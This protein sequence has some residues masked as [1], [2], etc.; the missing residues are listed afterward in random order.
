MLLDCQ[1]K[2]EILQ[3]FSVGPQYAFAHGLQWDAWVHA[4][5]LGAT[6]AISSTALSQSDRLRYR[7]RLS[8]EWLPVHSS[9]LG[10][11]GRICGSRR[12][13]GRSRNKRV[14]VHMRR[15]SRIPRA[16]RPSLHTEMSLLRI[17]AYP[18]Y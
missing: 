18:H 4:L 1:L 9:T 3:T 7:I 8:N 10:L 12:T 2:L 17:P 11:E 16:V 5:I 14:T 13:T 6:Q 15:V